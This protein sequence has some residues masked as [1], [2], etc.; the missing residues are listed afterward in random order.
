MIVCCKKHMEFAIDD[1]V[2]EYEEAPDVY[3]LSEVTFTAWTAPASCEYCEGEP[4]YLVV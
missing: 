2:D 4:N 1:F 3:K